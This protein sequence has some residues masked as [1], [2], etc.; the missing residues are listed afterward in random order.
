M[1][2]LPKY[3]L[4]LIIF[5]LAGV[6]HLFAHT[7][8][9]KSDRHGLGR[10]CSINGNEVFFVSRTPQKEQHHHLLNVLI[11]SESEN[12]IIS[13]KKRLDKSN[14]FINV[15]GSQ[16]AVRDYCSHAAVTLS[17]HYFS[18]DRCLLIRVFRI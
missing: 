5:L 17:N 9:V 3:L 1:S 10:V 18:S 12:E 16:T 8:S 13:L 15:Y 2:A 4:S 14:Y 11:E 6:G 7:T